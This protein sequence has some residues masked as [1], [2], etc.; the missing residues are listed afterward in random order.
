MLTTIEWTRERLENCE[1]LASKN[2]RGRAGWLA[3]AGYYRAIL[4]D[5]ESLRLMREFASRPV[6]PDAAKQRPP[7][8]R[9]P[10]DPPAHC[11]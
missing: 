5:L 1:R 4:T 9:R 11:P 7:D 2:S 10:A 6:N 3:D 8:D